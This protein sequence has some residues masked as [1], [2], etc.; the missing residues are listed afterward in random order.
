[1]KS[2]YIVKIPQK[3]FKNILRYHIEILKIEKKDNYYYLYLDLKNYQ[4]ILKYSKIYQIEFISIQG[5][6]KYQILF[7]KYLLF[8]V[9]LIITF[10]Y[11]FFLANVIFKIEIKTNN[12]EIKE[13]LLQELKDNDIKIF[14]FSKSYLEKEE[15]KKNILSKNK[16]KL[17]W[18]EITRRGS[19]Y[20]VDVEE[21]IIHEEEKEQSPQNI[22]ASK[23]AIIL[24]IEASKGSIVKKLNDYVKKGDIIVTGEITHKDKVV[25]YIQA[26]ATI[27]GE[28][29]YNV[30][31]S[32]PFAYYEKIYTGKK[33]KRLSIKFLNKEM[34]IGKSFLQEDVEERRIIYHNFIPWKISL[35]KVQETI[36]ID[37]FYTIEEAYERGMKL[38]R[39]VLLKRLGSDS[40]ILNQKKLKII[41]NNST[42]D[43]DIFF[44]VY[45]NITEIK[46]IE[47]GE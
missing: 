2:I 34:Q 20:I 41:I 32:Y 14:S 3:F 46:K 5:L 11:I 10:F 43:M 35:E 23:N 6:K 1:M 25:D 33:G 47:N 39:E 42:I 4:K 37:D 30:H 21:R 36:I 31:V 19:S 27:Y 24:S 22:V 45:E 28:T 15:I 44:K 13:L 12:I 29:W 16:D 9:I 38:A 18:I 7:K 40:K 26:K 17:E 8:I